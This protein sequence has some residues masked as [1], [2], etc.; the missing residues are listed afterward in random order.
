[1]PPQHEEALYRIAQ[2]ALANVLKHARA[3]RASITIALRDGSVGVRVVDD[4]VG[5]PAERPA[6]DAF[7]LRGMRE[8]VRALGGTVQ[9]GNGSTGGAY[10]SAELPVASAHDGAAFPSGMRDA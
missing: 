8:R 1:L 4:G 10:V 2:E 9:V 3:R 7:G 5:F 6:V